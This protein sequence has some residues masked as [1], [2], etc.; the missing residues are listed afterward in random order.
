[1][2]VSRLLSVVENGCVNKWRGQNLADINYDGKQL[3]VCL[4]EKDKKRI[5]QTFNEFVLLMV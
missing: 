3:F 2:Q 4:I 1:V 5:D